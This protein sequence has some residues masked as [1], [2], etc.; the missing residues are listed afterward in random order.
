MVYQYNNFRAD[1]ACCY[2]YFPD[3][4]IIAVSDGKQ[5]LE[6]LNYLPYIQTAV[7]IQDPCIETG[8]GVR[9]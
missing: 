5:G 1:S 8:D 7:S 6:K 2:G 9:L 3:T 4:H